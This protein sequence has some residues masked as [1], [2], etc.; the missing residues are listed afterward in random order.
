MQSCWHYWYSLDK[1]GEPDLPPLHL[2]DHNIYRY[3][4]LCRGMYLPHW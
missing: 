3:D 2:A 1:S 4:A